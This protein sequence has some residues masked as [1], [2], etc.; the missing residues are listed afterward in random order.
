M[1]VATPSL[2]VLASASGAVVAPARRTALLVAGACA[3][4]LLSQ[5][6]ILAEALGDNPFAQVPINDA[7]VYWERAG[8]I[9]EGRLVGS[10]PFLSAPLYPYLVAAVRA[11]GGGLAAVYVMQALL[12]AATAGLLARLAARRFG[13]ATGALAA[14]LYLLC[15]DPAA[16]TSR[17]LAGT[18]QAFLAVLLL[19]GM[20]SAAERPATSR[21]A[22]AG[23]LLG[24][25]ALA[26]A[27]LLPALPLLAAW[28]FLAAG[29]GRAGARAAAAC[30]VAAILLIAPATLHNRLASGEWI[31]LSAHGGV[32]FQAGN[33]P[34]ADGTYHALEGIA[35][36]SRKQN[37]DARVQAGG[38]RPAGWGETSSY[39]FRRGL[40]WWA[41][42]PGEALL[43]AGRKVW[44]FLTGRVYG[45]IQITE[46]EIRDGFASRLRLAPVPVAWFAFPALLGAFW[47]LRRPVKWFPELLLALL[48]LLIV[49]AF[50]Y[51]PRYRLPAVPFLA[52]LAAHALLHARRHPLHPAR[53]IAAALAILLSLST[54]MINRGAGVDQPARYRAQYELAAG[55]V[56]SESGR[57]EEAERRFRAAR[58]LGHVAAPAALGDLLASQGRT[59]EALE[60]LEAAAGDS[61]REAYIL[62]SLAV[63]LA[64]EG[65]FAESRARFEVA[66]EVDP[67]DWEAL[68]GLGN[69]LLAQGQAPAALERYESA[70]ALHPGFASAH[71]NRGVALATTGRLAEAEASFG[72]ALRLQP[73]LLESRLRMVQIAVGRGDEASA[74]RSLREGLVHAPA[75]PG[76]LNGL[77]WLLATARDPGLRD[78]PAAL[79]IAT[80]LAEHAASDDPGVLDTLA[81]ALA[82]C[83]RFE[84]AARTARRSRDLFRAVP[85][86]VAAAQV[87]ARIQAYLAGRAWHGD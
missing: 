85:D 82:E 45:D 20:I 16:A 61:P 31:P 22:L 32:T 15:T 58:S 5:A 40:S 65:R 79:R 81:A 53:S 26:N 36:D 18:L 41:R 49:A 44:W 38:G 24:L 30:F 2:E 63:V 7:R 1:S 86:E 68:S 57:R 83:G 54:S 70:I 52:L 69:V 47:L 50:W 21:F 11:L 29:R 37:L 12:H 73:G 14:A 9:A 77:A 43:L 87:E 56:L 17:V 34:G 60:V 59:Q 28:A 27:A 25:G 84:E 4:G 23:A 71:H 78:G 33:A 13:T 51:S 62:R 74:L 55:K 39:F 10:T 80:T 8:E 66:L 76:L 19:G 48:P 46:L 6:L 42:E 3:L 75:E 64:R 35:A 72:E 67:H